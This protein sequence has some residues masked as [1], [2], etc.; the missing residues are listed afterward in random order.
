MSLTCLAAWIAALI[1][2]PL[3]VLF[4]LAETPE[5]RIHRLRSYGW[6]QARIASHLHLS[7]YAVRK[8]LAT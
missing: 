7:R 8:A 2:L 3:V 4:W 6:S 1:L 5:Q